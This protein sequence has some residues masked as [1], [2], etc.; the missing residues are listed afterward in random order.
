MVAELAIQLSVMS[1]KTIRKYHTDTSPET[2]EE[3][4]SLIYTIKKTKVFLY[5]KRINYRFPAVAFLRSGSGFKEKQ[6]KDFFTK[7]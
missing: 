2:R 1:L 5:P 7:I 4:N 3:T 6:A